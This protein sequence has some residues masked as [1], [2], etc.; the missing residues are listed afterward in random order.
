[1]Q[2]SNNAALTQRVAKAGGQLSPVAFEMQAA[3]WFKNNK[4]KMQTLAGG[5]LKVA[6]QIMVALIQSVSKVP[7]LLS[8]KPE[9]LFACV[10][11]SA[12]TNLFPGPLQE[13]AYVPF[14][15]EAT[16]MPMYQGLCKLAFNGGHVKGISSNVVYEA[17]DFDY[18][19]GS[20]PFVH[21]KM[22]LGPQSQRGERVA[23]YSSVETLHGRIV[24]VKSMDFIQGI[25]K[26]SK[27]AKFPDSPWNGSADD[28]DAMACKTVLKQALKVVPKSPRMAQAL[29]YDNEVEGNKAPAAT[30]FDAVEM[31]SR[32]GLE[33]KPKDTQPA[34]AGD[35]GKPS[36]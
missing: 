27:G 25:K 34:S 4:R 8:C 29:E 2:T 9:T 24:V 32:M 23:T 16:W 35:S 15:D 22:F 13:C 14:A 31:A 36:A 30:V 33:E 11:H 3:D 1:M 10:M 7:K 5:D 12:A 18:Q 26:R 19:Q 6:Q 28:F 21:H 17:D 20:N